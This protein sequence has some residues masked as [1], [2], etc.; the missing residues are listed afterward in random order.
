M[1][2]LLLVGAAPLVG[3]CADR[4]QEADREGVSSNLAAPPQPSTEDVD[5]AMRALAGALAELAL[6]ETELRELV[7]YERKTGR[8]PEAMVKTVWQRGDYPDITERVGEVE[9][10]P[11]REPVAPFEDLSRKERL[12]LWMDWVGDPGLELTCWQT[13]IARMNMAD[14]E[15]ADGFDSLNR[16]WT[17]T[18]RQELATLWLDAR[19]DSGVFRRMLEHNWLPR[20]AS[21]LSGRFFEPWHEAFSAGNGYLKEVTAPEALE[22]IADEVRFHLLEVARK[23]SEQVAAQSAQRGDSGEHTAN[24][25]APGS[26]FS[27]LLME[28]I[29]EAVDFVMDGH[30]FFYF[31]VYGERPGSI[32]AEGLWRVTDYQKYVERKARA[33]AMHPASSPGAAGDA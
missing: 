5:R 17:D 12:L 2:C 31:R 19:R 1:L 6:P 33:A 25:P 18:D 20:F 3:G 27:S 4:P 30:K 21:P 29:D 28:S 24:A 14:V 23:R 7:D 15:F 10:L 13:I 26:R 11:L 22:R 32:V 8:L 9:G 16:L